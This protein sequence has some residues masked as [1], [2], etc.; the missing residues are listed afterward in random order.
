[1]KKIREITKILEDAGWEPQLCDTP[2]PV[3]ESV[4]AGNPA[5]PGQ[6]PPG[7]VLMPK[8]LFA[9][10]DLMV[11]VVGNSMIDIGIED[12]CWVKMRP[13]CEPRD[14]DIVVVAIGQECTV[15]GYYEDD[16]GSR[17]L[18]PQNRAEKEKYRVIRL[19]EHLDSVCLCGVVTEVMKPLPRVT[20]RA[21]RSLVKEAKGGYD[22][23]PRFSEQRISGVIRLLAKDIKVAR[24]WYAVCRSMIDELI[25]ADDDYDAFC[26]RV[27]AT[28]PWH[29][30]LPRPDDMRC[31]AV[32]SF[33]KNISR[34][35]E[36]KA[37]VKGKRFRVYKTIAERTTRLLTMN[38]TDFQLEQ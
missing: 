32:E 30:H 21:M 23:A 33:A 34:W 16:D 38:E 1:M 35:D 22:D 29:K 11:K 10:S 17:W 37:P 25:Y 3:Y 26:Q 6:I 9:H 28:V 7:W 5:D 15:K 24:H 4:H 8:A 2:V 12:G 13:C 31:M 19:D 18:V 36:R 27:A 20:G 14:G